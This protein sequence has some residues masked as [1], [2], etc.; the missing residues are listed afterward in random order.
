MA[1]ANI[2]GAKD[3]IENELEWE[4]RN[5]YENSRE[6]SRVWFPASPG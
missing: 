3:G 6:S 1:N 5:G 4:V 2:N